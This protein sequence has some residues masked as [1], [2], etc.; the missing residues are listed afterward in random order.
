MEDNIKNILKEEK[1][2]KIIHWVVF[3]LIM[4]LLVSFFYYLIIKNSNNTTNTNKTNDIPVI[5]SNFVS[6]NKNNDYDVNLYSGNRDRN[7][8]G[9]LINNEISNL[10]GLNILDIGPVLDYNFITKDYGFYIKQDG[11]IMSFQLSS[12]NGYNFITN[13]LYKIKQNNIIGAVF[14][15]TSKYLSIQNN[16]KV[17]FVYK[18]N[19]TNPVSFV[20]IFKKEGLYTYTFSDDE[21]Y[22]Y[23]TLTN[24]RGGSSVFS[25]DLN[26]FVVKKITDMPIIEYSLYSNNNGLFLK[27]K[28]TD[29]YTQNIFKINTNNGDINLISDYNNDTSNNFIRKNKKV[30]FNNTPLNINTSLEKCSENSDNVFCF[31]KTLTSFSIDAWYKKKYNTGDVLTIY[32]KKG[33][34]SNISNEIADSMNLDIISMKTNND[35]VLFING[36]S[37]ELWVGNVNY[38]LN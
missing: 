31:Y 6:N 9:E 29:L 37:K 2:K 18:N 8:D 13:K 34:V 3:I 28:A 11:Q 17:L 14:S 16:D 38:L 4:L 35:Y 25:F 22:L 10:V 15:T 12:N 7:S 30:L 27:T 33:A 1:Q 36:D 21:K 20:Q 23:Y 5:D 19:Y 26:S 24:D 32:N